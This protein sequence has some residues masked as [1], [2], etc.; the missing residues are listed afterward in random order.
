M[1][2]LVLSSMSANQD[3]KVNPTVVSSFL[4][5]VVLTG[6]FGIFWSASK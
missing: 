4:G 2:S 5:T 3:L 6:K 1:E